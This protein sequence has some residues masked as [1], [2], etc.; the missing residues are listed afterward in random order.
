MMRI[1]DLRE[2]LSLSFGQAWASSFSSDIAISA[3]NSLTVNEALAQGY[4][5]QEIWRAVCSEHPVETSQY[6]Y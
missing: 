2:R 5:A 1:S 4:E 6:K 3:L